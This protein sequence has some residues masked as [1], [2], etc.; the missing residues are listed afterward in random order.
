MMNRETA[1]FVFG[2]WVMVGGNLP[3]KFASY[4]GHKIVERIYADLSDL[5]NGSATP[6]NIFIEF[7]DKTTLD[8]QA[9]DVMVYK[10]GAKT[11]E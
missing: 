3:P 1:V 6:A 8:I 9:R 4:L 2:E 7:E 10:E 11:N 5:R